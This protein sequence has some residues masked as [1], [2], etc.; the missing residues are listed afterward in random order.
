MGLVSKVVCTVRGYGVE[1]MSPRGWKLCLFYFLVI[2]QATERNRGKEIL[3]SDC[4]DKCESGVV[5][6]QLENYKD[7]SQLHRWNEKGDQTLQKNAQ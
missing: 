5:A 2:H 7:Y 3:R 6:T 1:K 4:Y